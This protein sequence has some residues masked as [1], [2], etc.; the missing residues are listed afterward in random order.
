MLS[1]RLAVADAY[2]LVHVR[3]NV[4]YN[5]LHDAVSGLQLSDVHSES[6]RGFIKKV[7]YL[8]PRVLMQ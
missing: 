7:T 1:E 3:C 4:L 8:R 2:F 6:S 5:P